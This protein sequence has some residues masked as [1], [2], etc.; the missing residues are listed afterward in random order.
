MWPQTFLILF[1]SWLL[2]SS[3]FFLGKCYFICALSVERRK[4]Y[5]FGTLSA[6]DA[7][8]VSKVVF[9]TKS[10]ITVFFVIVVIIV[11]VF[12]FLFSLPPKALLT[13]WKSHSLVLME[14][15][16]QGR[17][18][19]LCCCWRSSIRELTERGSAASLRQSRNTCFV[20]LVTIFFLAN[21]E[22]SVHYARFIL[23]HQ[24]KKNNLCWRLIR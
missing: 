23:R 24:R 22:K 11:A 13:L 14:S 7:H 18:Q 10:H 15:D 19:S 6:D 4:E 21:T 1:S 9:K 3:I 8:S 20:L 5:Q 17:M 2:I 12:S 16:T